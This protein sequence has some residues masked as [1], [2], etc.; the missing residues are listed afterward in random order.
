M[1]AL[2]QKIDALDLKPITDSLVSRYGWLRSEA[3]EASEQ[4]RRYLFLVGKYSFDDGGVSV[5]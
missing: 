1:D 3:Q 2:R 4:Y 5:L